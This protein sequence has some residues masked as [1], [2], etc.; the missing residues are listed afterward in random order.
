M[1]AK[2]ARSIQITGSSQGLS[3]AVEQTLDEVETLLAD[4]DL[5]SQLC[6]HEVTPLERLM[7]DRVEVLRQWFNQVKAA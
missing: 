5:D 3:Q 7:R 6:G 1:S 4:C 2:P